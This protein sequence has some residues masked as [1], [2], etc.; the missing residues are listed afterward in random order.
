MNI[1]GKV[2]IVGEVREGVS[3]NGPWKRQE[4]V[5]ETLGDYPKKVNIE[6]G[7]PEMLEG[8]AKGDIIDAQI[9]PESKESNGKWFSHI[10]GIAIKKLG[11]KEGE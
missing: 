2:I 7:R 5:I 11:R 10:R 8:I 6:F 4:I 9:S 1:A 3:A